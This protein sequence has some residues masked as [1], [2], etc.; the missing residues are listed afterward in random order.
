MDVRIINNSS[1]EDI[2]SI[3]TDIVPSI[4]DQIY[5]DTEDRQRIFTV[6]SIINFYKV[7]AYENMSHAHKEVYVTEI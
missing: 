7:V 3:E 5:L 6:N 1:G 2:L 4:G